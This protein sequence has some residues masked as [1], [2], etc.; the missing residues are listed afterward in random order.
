MKTKL[1]EQLEVLLNEFLTTSTC[2][3]LP[4][5]A[6]SKYWIVSLLWVICLLAS[7]ITCCVFVVFTIIQ[8]LN[9]DVVTTI[10]VDYKVRFIKKKPG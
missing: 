5:I 4:N 8:Y 6:R 3:G 1:R 7:S 9:Y 10:R 2:H